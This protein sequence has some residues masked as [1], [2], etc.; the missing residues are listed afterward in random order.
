MSILQALNLNAQRQGTQNTGIHSELVGEGFNH[1][2]YGAPS[3]SMLWCRNI[4]GMLVA[5]WAP[6]LY[7][8]S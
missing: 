4:L 3:G 1:S 2:N 7:F 6:Q 8:T 5:N